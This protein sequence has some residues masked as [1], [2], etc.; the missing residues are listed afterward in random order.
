MAVPGAGAARDLGRRGEREAVPAHRRDGG[1][2]Q[3]RVEHRARGVDERGRR[4]EQGEVA[5]RDAADRRD[6][7]ALAVRAAARDD[8]HARAEELQRGERPGGGARRDA[9]HVVQEEHDEAEHRRLRGDEQ[10]AGRAEAPQARVAGRRRRGH[11]VGSGRSGGGASRMN[12][13]AATAAM[14]QR[15]A[16]VRNAAFRPPASTSCGSATERGGAAERQRH[17]ADAEREA[18]LLAPNQP[19]TAR[20][21][22]PVEL[23]PSIPATSR[24][25]SSRP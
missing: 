8:A 4:G 2:R 1:E 17:L 22:A 10:R 6:P 16:R 14:R 23:A 13:T 19:I 24:P 15:P 21:L 11:D 9:A 7:Q 3:H 5:H 25:T 12:A 20:P 18:A